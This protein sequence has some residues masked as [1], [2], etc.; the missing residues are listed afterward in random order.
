MSGLSR[1]KEHNLLFHRY[2]RN[3]HRMNNSIERVLRTNL[4]VQPIHFLLAI[5]TNILNIFVL[6]SCRTFRLSLCTYYFFAH[7]I[8]SIIYTCLVCP[9][10]FS[11]AFSMN[12]IHGPI[13]C[14]SHVFLLFVLPLQANLMLVLASFDRYYSSYQIS[15]VYSVRTIRTRARRNILLSNL[16]CIFYMIPMI[17]IYNRDESS[18]KCLPKSHSFVQIYVFSQ[19]VLYYF[20]SP[21]LMLLFGIL[22]INHIHRQSKRCIPLLV[23]IHRRRTECQLTRMLFLQVTIHLIL[24]LPFGVIYVIH[25]LIPSTQTPTSIA[26]RLVFVSWQQCDYFVS[27]VL[28]ILSGNVYREQFIRLF[29]RQ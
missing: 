29:H 20:L 1:E 6:S 4:Y 23:S 14:Q 21:F 25:S 5:T 12:W 16:I 15:H 2:F 19:I 11:R 27:F 8:L 13:I 24:V 26:L 18:N 7:A 22:T 28:Y 10:Q 9:I 17:F 3:P